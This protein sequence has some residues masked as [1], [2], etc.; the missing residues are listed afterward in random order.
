MTVGERYEGSSYQT[1]SAAGA[2]KEESKGKE[3]PRGRHSD[4]ERSAPDAAA[5]KKGEATSG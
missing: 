4:K 5:S 2:G 3:S 1:V